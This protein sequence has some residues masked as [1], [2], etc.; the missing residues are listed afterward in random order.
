MVTSTTR[1]TPVS[2]T[3]GGGRATPPVEAVT[4]LRRLVRVGAGLLPGASPDLFSQ[5]QRT[6]WLV[7]VASLAPGAEC[8]TT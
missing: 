6:L 3:T 4:C 8:A 7:V 2:E 5:T 1:G